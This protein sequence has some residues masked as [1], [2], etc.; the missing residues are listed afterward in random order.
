VLFVTNLI[1][2]DA[3]RKIYKCNIPTGNI[4]TSWILTVTSVCSRSVAF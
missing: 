4:I 3:L 1:V 2:T